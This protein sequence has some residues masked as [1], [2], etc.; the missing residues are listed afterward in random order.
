MK[1]LFLIACCFVLLVSCGRNPFKV[2]LSNTKIDF[3]FYA[4]DTDLFAAGTNLEQQLPDLEKKYPNI[5][6]LFSSEIITIGYPE[7]EGFAERLNSFVSDSLI[8]EVKGKVDAT[9]DRNQIKDGLQQAFRYFNYYFPDKVIPEVFTCISGFNQSVIMTDSLMGIGLDK[10]LGRD[11]NYYPRLGIPNYQTIN[12]N[13]D[14]IVSDAMYAWSTTIFP[15]NGYGQQLID[16]MIY[17]G[18]MLYL[19]D[20]T[21]PDTPD[22]LKIGYTQKQLEFCSI[23]ENAMW[24]YLAE[25]KMLFSTERMDIKRYVDDSPYTS[26]FTADSPGRTGAWLGWQIVKAYMNKHSEVTIPELMEEKD[27][28]KILN[29]SG[30]QPE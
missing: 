17:E 26:S 30:Y 11:C 5:L 22:S 16:R 3:Q 14:K 23:K 1:K 6:P 10:Y 7:D 8:L 29:L 27:C 25:Y 20:A 9:I 2:D 24:T 4:F 21:L 13:P 28:K 12:M 19:L 18:K 15:F